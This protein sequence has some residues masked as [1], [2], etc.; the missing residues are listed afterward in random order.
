MAVSL[1]GTTDGLARAGIEPFAGILYTSQAGSGPSLQNCWLW[2]IHTICPCMYVQDSKEDVTG[3]HSHHASGR[4]GCKRS[5]THMVQ[6]ILYSTVSSCTVPYPNAPPW[7]SAP[8]DGDDAPAPRPRPRPAPAPAA[9]RVGQERQTR[10]MRTL[11]TMYS[12]TQGEG[13]RCSHVRILAQKQCT[14]FRFLP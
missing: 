3:L 10:T 8:G 4:C 1:S 14:Q 5:H 13:N 11:H 2:C 7:S 9:L 12:N 6:Y